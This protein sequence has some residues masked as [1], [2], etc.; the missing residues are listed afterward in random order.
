MSKK[1]KE[2]ASAVEADLQQTT[3]EAA[4]DGQSGGEEVV[5]K[6]AAKKAKKDRKRREKTG[7]VDT[8]ATGMAVDGVDG[9]DGQM[10]SRADAS[11]IQV[12]RYVCA[13]RCTATDVFRVP[14]K[15]LAVSNP[16]WTARIQRRQVRKQGPQEAQSHG[17]R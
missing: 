17:R 2:S 13:T 15:W 8:S 5:G 9:V 7:L 3:M 11:Q 1:K 6:A 14:L 10:A 4:V 16:A 12:R